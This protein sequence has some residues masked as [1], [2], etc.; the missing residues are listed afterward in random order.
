MQSKN[1]LSLL[2]LYSSAG[3]DYTEK[4]F[5]KTHDK[6]LKA[7]I[8]HKNFIGDIVSDLFQN[9]T[10]FSYRK[11]IHSVWLTESGNPEKLTFSELRQLSKKRENPRSHLPDEDAI[12][13]HFKRV[14]GVYKYMLRY[15]HDH[16]PAVEWCNY[17]F[18][19]DDE[20][21]QFHPKIFI[22][23]IHLDSR[24]R[25]QQTTQATAICDAKQPKKNFK[26]PE[27]KEQLITEFNKSPTLTNETLTKLIS[28]TGLT[29]KKI[30]T[31]FSKE[32]TKINQKS[33]GKNDINS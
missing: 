31:W 15:I 28:T 4:W 23:E 17:G 1:T 32:R 30:Q 5:G 14:H 8:E 7:F 25:K 2:V 11:L 29:R 9:L 19:Y 24:K 27:Q 16:L 20:T 33:K 12:L 21:K 10:S 22:P 13:Q 18:E 6:F 3:S 26:T